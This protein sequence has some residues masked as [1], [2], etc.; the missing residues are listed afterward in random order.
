VLDFT[1]PKHPQV[2]RNVSA[3]VK[4]IYVSYELDAV[5]SAVSYLLARSLSE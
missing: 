4:V 5:Q 2:F 1:L 3:S